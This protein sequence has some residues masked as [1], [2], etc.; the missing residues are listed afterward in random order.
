[1]FAKLGG[2][3]RVALVTSMDTLCMFQSLFVGMNIL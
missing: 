3:L 2:V 1:M